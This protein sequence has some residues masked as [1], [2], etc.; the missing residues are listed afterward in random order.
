MRKHLL[1]FIA[2][3]LSIG[4]GQAVGQTGIAP[5]GSVVSSSDT[6]TVHG[7][8]NVVI[9]GDFDSECIYDYK[10]RV[11]EEYPNFMIACKHSTVTYTCYANMG[12]S[13]PVSYVWSVIGDQN[14]SVSGNQITVDWGDDE[15]GMLFVSVVGTNGDTC[16]GSSQVKL[17]DSPTVG[18]TTVPTY[19]L[20]PGGEKVIRVCKGASIVFMDDSH[21][22][23][24]DIAGYHW[25]STLPNVNPSS[26][27]NYT[28]ESV[29]GPG[30]VT[31]RVFNNCG[32]MDEEKIEIEILEGTNLELECYGTVC[33]DEQVTYKVITPDCS[34]YHW[35]V[36]GGS[37]VSGQ[38]T[39][40]PVVQWGNPESGYGVIGLDGYLCGDEACPTMMSKKVAVIGPGRTIQG[41]T[42]VCVGES[43]VYTLP[44]MGS[45][46]YNWS[47]S[48]STGA[49]ADFSV[50]SHELRVTFYSPG[51]YQLDCSYNC[52]FLKCGPYDAEP[53]TINVRP[54]FDITGVDQICITNSC[55]LQTTPSVNAHWVAYDINNNN[56]VVASSN[57][58]SFNH[59]FDHPG[60]YLITAENSS[61]CG[62]STFVLI[63][64]DVPGAPTVDDLA[65]YNPHVACP[66]GGI[67]LAGTPSSPNYSLVWEPE[68]STASP[69]Q[70]S[71]DS[72]T[73]SYQAEVCNVNVYYYDRVLQCMSENYLVHQVSPFA[74]APLSLPQ[75]ITVCPNSTV[76]WGNNQVPDQ[77]ADGVLYE[78]KIQANKQ[79]CASVQGSQFSNAVTLAINNVATPE[80]FYVILTRR[81]CNGYSNDTVF[82]NIMNI[83]NNLSINGP[84]SV[85]AGS[86]ATFTGIGGN[87]SSYSWNIEGSAYSGVNVS[88]T[89]ERPGTRTVTLYSNPYT[90]CNNPDFLNKAVKIVTVNPLPMLQGILCNM[91]NN[92]VSVIPNPGSGYSFY[93][94]FQAMEGAPSQSLPYS[95]VQ[96]PMT[97]QGIY[98]CV[99]VNDQTGC[100]RT[101]I[102]KCGCDI[103]CDPMTLTGDYDPCTQSISL[104]ASQAIAPDV[105]WEVV[106]GPYSIHTSG[107]YHRDA[108]ITFNTV[109]IYTVAAMT[110]N[111]PDCYAA[112]RT[113]TVDFIPDFT[114]T[115]KCDRV[116]ITNN[117][118]YV[119]GST[120]VYITVTRGANVVQVIQMPVS[121]LSRVF[122]PSGLMQFG[123]FT[124]TITG[125]G[126]NGNMSCVI[127]TVNL[128]P[129]LIQVGVDPVSITTANPYSQSATCNNTPIMLTA[130]LGYSGYIVSSTWNFGDAS[131][132]ETAGNSISHTFA[133]GS[134]NVTVTIVDN[135]GCTATSRVKTITSYN[136]PFNN[137]QLQQLDDDVCPDATPTIRA[138]FTPNSSSYHYSWWTSKQPAHL[139]GSNPHYTFPYSDLNFA[140]V[141]NN[142][143]CQKEAS[144]FIIYP[145]PPAAF[146]YAENYVVCVDDVVNLYGDQGP[147][148]SQVSYLW[149][150]TSPNG[151]TPQQMT[152]PNI[153]FVAGI[154]GNYT[155][156]LTVTDNGPAGC[157]STATETIHVNPRPAAPIINFVDSGCISHAPVHLQ[158]TGYS[159][160]MHWSNGNS[161]PD[162]Y[163]YTH[164]VLTAYYFD[165]VIGCTSETAYK[166]IVK[167][168]D[169]DALLTGCYE[170]CK[171]F[172]PYNLPVYGFTDAFQD[173]RWQWNLGYYLADS[174]S[175]SYY[176][177][178]LQLPLIG[179]GDYQLTLSYNHDSCFAESPILRINP[180]RRCECDSINVKYERDM[181]I[182][183]CRIIYTYYISVCNESHTK[184]C[185]GDLE[186]LALI[187]EDID[188]LETDFGP[189]S[190]EG[191]DCYHFYIKIEVLD[192]LPTVAGFNLVNC[193]NTCD[194]YFEL[195]LSLDKIG[196]ETW[197]EPEWIELDY[198]WSSTVAAYF[199]IGLHVGPTQHLYAF[200]TEPP[201]VF[202]YN[203]EDGAEVIDALIMVDY[204]VL[205]Q[206]IYEGGKICFYAI[207]CEGDILCK[208]IYCMDPMKIYELLQEMGI[209]PKSAVA[210]GDETDESALTGDTD[211]R[212]MPNP[213]T[214]EFSIV[215]ANGNIVEV[216]V[217]D[218][219][220]R[221]M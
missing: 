100:S 86:S 145:N 191:Q 125:F 99:V 182:E 66:Y 109:G 58:T 134:N 115:R 51:T 215:G 103:G 138:F 26:N 152:T 160:E 24:S 22:G 155:I 68:C 55:N 216:L 190:I 179:Y 129:N 221:K 106:G 110:G 39:P 72:V 82:V 194:K 171:D 158:A 90:Y 169:F 60:R 141:M 80:S 85:C 10:E 116:E 27:P 144:R 34:E 79:H 195:D 121:Q 12:S 33:R 188:I 170:R 54:K 5:G 11:M 6:A 185:L 2:L 127:G 176:Y 104:H 117:S 124:F 9:T 217:M 206:L 150:V 196:C 166:R 43:V 20:L 118:Q 212:I 180:D 132:Y 69:Q 151:G 31:H 83:Q 139:P 47:I 107:L 207:T 164:G 48:P 97:L 204:S 105:T 62:P 135:K 95:G 64:K 149:T 172:F 174:N 209:E 37:L 165:P 108:D 183:D 7:Q 8:C 175:G 57:G 203:H 32:C 193:G 70:H 77:S 28:I 214:G 41:Q 198:E 88:H 197:M 153:S 75:N 1:F 173:I 211:P 136:S 126:V 161:G 81:Y 13:S 23:N 133:T 16:L 168:P 163:Y 202:N 96:I 112:S 61:Y 192:M 210:N 208:Y 63:V 130:N 113:V 140:S 91:N 102:G 56:Q 4:I 98:T 38:G 200:W 73:I 181:H 52:D 142:N 205:T 101:L 131:S 53:L 148:G 14:H 59:T 50:K 114:L 67:V 187:G 18:S 93:W 120:I 162:A 128:S 189:T 220:G 167:E 42:D 78:W 15:W 184:F 19:T 122:V 159:G 219:N 89:F 213:T 146:I 30:T 84:G 186:P 143:Y 147:S 199:K 156:T 17:I 40:T 71:G 29:E 76:Y 137:A 201:M 25:E 111:P 45:T 36:E 46:E 65:S 154:A 44:I 3:F 21:A 35:Y 74:P 119:N 178:P 218:V 157:S 49:Q 177:N 94:S 92:T 123:N 87:P